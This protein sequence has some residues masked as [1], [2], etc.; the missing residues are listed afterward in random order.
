[1]TKNINDKLFQDLFRLGDHSSWIQPKQKENIEWFKKEAPNLELRDVY[2]K[3][4]LLIK[5]IT[6][7]VEAGA[8]PSNKTYLVANVNKVRVLEQAYKLGADPNMCGKTG[9]SICYRA[10]SRG[11]TDI[12]KLTMEQPSFDFNAQF[13]P[14]TPGDNI[15]L[16]SIAKGRMELANQI[17]DLN[18]LLSLKSDG[19]GNNAFDFI[20]ELMNSATKPPKSKILLLTN[21]ICEIHFSNNHIPRM[22]TK[23][24][25]INT[26]LAEKFAHK[27]SKEMAS[28]SDAKSVIKSIKI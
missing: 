16:S 8:N 17:I 9:L 7:L 4:D 22:N 25:D 12:V 28:T 23:S 15:L 26:L 3:E 2:Q 14:R 27:L 11:R 19:N 10:I 13:D 5:R 1:M 24:E 6:E 18:P 21:R 20:G